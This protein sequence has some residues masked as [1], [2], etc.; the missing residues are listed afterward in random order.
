MSAHGPEERAEPVY[1]PFRLPP[2]E[3]MMYKKQ[4][5]LR[6]TQFK[7]ANRYQ[8]NLQNNQKQNNYHSKP[9]KNYWKK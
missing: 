6:F 9:V 1:L 2:S 4:R 3:Q 8:E 5:T 7:D